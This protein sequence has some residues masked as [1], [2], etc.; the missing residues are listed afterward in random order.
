MKQ[1][2]SL[3]TLSLFLFAQDGK[4]DKSFEDIN[5]IDM[6]IGA[7]DVV[8]VKSATNKVRVMVEFDSDEEENKPRIEKRGKKLIIKERRKGRNYFFNNRSSRHEWHLEV[9]NGL[10]LEFSTGSG[11]VDVTGVEFTEAELNS[12]SGKIKYTDGSGD[13]RINT[14]SGRI[15]VKNHKGNIKSNTGSGGIE[16]SKIDG[17]VHGNTGSGDIRVQNSKGGFRLNTGSG[18]I[19]IS[20]TDIIK[21]SSMNTGSGEVMLTLNKELSANLS[22]NAG[23]GD[24]TLKYNGTP[25]KGYIEMTAKRES[26]IRAPFTFDRTEKI[27][28]WGGSYVVKSASIKGDDPEISLSTGSGRV[29]IKD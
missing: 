15:T 16:L 8:I 1:F 13:A 29:T 3:L 11:D 27:D 19:E 23:S 6:E 14:G 25:I 10:E 26:R 2:I 28:Q 4:I 21:K 7:G 17:R 12:G 22:M 24:V 20:S 9:P 18:D 5:R